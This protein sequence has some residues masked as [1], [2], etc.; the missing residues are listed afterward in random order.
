MAVSDNKESADRI[1]HLSTQAKTDTF[2]YR[3]DEVGYN[4]RMT[5]IQAAIGLGQLERFDE[6]LE[7]KRKIH[8]EYQKAFKNIPDAF[9]FIEQAYCRS[10]Y[11]L[12]LLF[13]EKR[14]KLFKFMEERQI[15]TRPFWR[16]NHL[17]PMFA[18]CAKGKTAVDEKLFSSGVCIP[19]HAGM[20]DKEVETVIET[21]K[22]FFNK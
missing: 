5:N 7:R 15:Q 16:L 17:H 20:A 11:W 1:R 2:Y 21:V 14:E 9:L 3:H 8:A 19:C 13:T 12:G 22:E 6:M 18:D 10:N 4:Y